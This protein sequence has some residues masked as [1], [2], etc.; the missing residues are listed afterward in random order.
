MKTCIRTLLAAAVLAAASP[1]AAQT[2]KLGTLAPDGSPWLNYLRDMGEAWRGESAGGVELRIYPGG[3]AG[4]EQDMVRKLRIGQLHA[5]A[6]TTEGLS[7]IVPEIRALWLPML[8]Q[9]D[10]ELDY[11]RD[12]LGPRFESLLEQRGFKLLTWGD[13]GWVYLFAQ[14][15]VVRPADLK[16]LRLFTWAGDQAAADA[17]TQ[18]GYNP[19]PLAV[20]D[21]HG[22]LQSGLIQA[23]STT[24][25][26]ALSFQWFGLAA[27][28]TDVK[29]AP[30]PGA[31]VIT[32]AK[33]RTIRDDLKP[34]LLRAARDTGARLKG[35]IQKFNDDAVRVMQKHGLAVHPVP[36]AAVDL[37]EQD[38]R[39]G[40]PRLVGSGA[41]ADFAAEVERLRDEFR[42]R[43]GSQ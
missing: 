40:Y 35:S 30:L 22:A 33:W 38:A 12:R 14:E 17:W 19:V 13:A 7:S 15:P 31:V 34:P 1:L 42:A 10:A 18:A 2:V 16:P 5:A 6:L 3:V 29:W 4:D 39:A 32:M 8:L 36:P 26:A 24:P 11:V 25:V 20:T 27:H 41:T 21:M 28:M 43:G 23:F 37:W 9:S